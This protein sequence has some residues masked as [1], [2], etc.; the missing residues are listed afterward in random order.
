VLFN[1]ET[2]APKERADFKGIMKS[3]C[4]LAVLSCCHIKCY[5]FAYILGGNKS[6]SHQKLFPSQ[7]S[8]VEKP[9]EPHRE[10]SKIMGASR[11][12]R[13]LCNMASN[14]DSNPERFHVGDDLVEA[15]TVQNIIK[16]A[17]PAIGIWL[18]GPLLSLIDTSAVGMLS[19]TAQLA[20]L[21]PA[22]TITDDG[23]LLVV[24]YV[25]FY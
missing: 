13:V 7:R 19:G 20:A 15:P 14:C 6:V 23:A 21:N 5:C 2:S 10:R 18:C 16:F 8:I 12:H 9:W 25:F 11:E 22:I 4:I 24:S 17:I 1:L 3:I